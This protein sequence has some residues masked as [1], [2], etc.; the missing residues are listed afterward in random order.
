MNE[1]D[2]KKAIEEMKEKGCHIIDSDDI[3]AE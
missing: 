3:K 1:G 2:A